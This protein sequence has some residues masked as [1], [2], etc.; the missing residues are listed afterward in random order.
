MGNIRYSQ[1][2]LEIIMDIH[3]PW[4]KKQDAAFV[5]LPAPTSAD[6]TPILTPTNLTL[7]ENSMDSFVYWISTYWGK[8]SVQQAAAAMKLRETTIQGWMD[9]VIK[10]ITSCVSSG[11]PMPSIDEVVAEWH[12]TNPPATWQA[13]PYGDRPL[14]VTSAGSGT[15]A[16]LVAEIKE[17]LTRYGG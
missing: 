8:Q 3:W 6:M 10:Y 16:D 1:M 12:K 7:K 9:F 4:T 17:V 2:P 5:P 14:P 11:K 13:T 15:V